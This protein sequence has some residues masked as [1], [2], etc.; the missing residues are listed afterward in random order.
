MVKEQLANNAIIPL[1]ASARLLGGISLV[2]P[3]SENR[4]RAE[5]WPCPFLPLH[6]PRSPVRVSVL[7]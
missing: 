7:L 2:C 3:L 1:M 6:M 5:P 4:T